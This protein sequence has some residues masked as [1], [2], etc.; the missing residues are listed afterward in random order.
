[1]CY[2]N[3]QEVYH[4]RRVKINKHFKHYKEFISY[5][6]IANFRA[7]ISTRICTFLLSE[8]IERELALIKYF[9]HGNIEFCSYAYYILLDLCVGMAGYPNPLRTNR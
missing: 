3:F 8:L 6:N 9:I 5:I 7:K 1:M 4:E 2:N